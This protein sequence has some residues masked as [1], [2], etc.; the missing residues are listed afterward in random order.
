M[1]LFVQHSAP[2][3]VFFEDILKPST[4]AQSTRKLL[5]AQTKDSKRIKINRTLRSAPAQKTPG[6]VLQMIRI[7]AEE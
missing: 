7:L 4:K 5:K 1:V 2:K 6:T 3:E